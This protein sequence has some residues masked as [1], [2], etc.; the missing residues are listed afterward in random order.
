MKQAETLGETGMEKTETALSTVAEE[1]RELDLNFRDG[2]DLDVVEKGYARKLIH[3]IST[4]DGVLKNEVLKSLGDLY[5]RK[6]K[7]KKHKVEN[8]NKACALYDELLQYVRYKEER[9]VMQ[10]RIRYAEKC[11]QMVYSSKYAKDDL[12]MNVAEILH[13]VEKKA[14][15]KGNDVMILMEGYTDAFVEAI[16]DRNKRLEMESLK[17][18]GDLYLEK[19]RVGRDEA[20]FTK[21][22]GLYR[23][24]LDRCEDSDGREILKHRIK[25]AEKVKGKVKKETGHPGIEIIA[26]ET[27]VTC[28]QTVGHTT[29]ETQEDTDSTYQEQLQEGCR[30]LQTG[31]LDTAEEHFAAALK[32]V[33]AEAQHLEETEPLCK[34]SDVYLKRGMQSRDGGDF[35]K[36]AALSNAALV[37]AREGDRKGVK[38]AILEITQSFVKHVLS[39]NETAN[40]G[41]VD[42]EKHKRMLKEDRGYVEREIKKIEQQ[43]DPYSLDDDDPMLREVEKKRAEAIKALCETIVDQRRKFIAG[44]VDECMEVMGPPPCKYAMI[45]L[46]SQATGL[47]TPYSDLEFAIL[48]EK[49]TDDNVGYFRNLTHYLHLKVINLGE[50][51]LPAMAI[52]SLN[53]FSS[54][55]P[56]D[57]W[58][59]DSVTPRGFAFDG[60]MP[61][62][63]KTPLGRGET[64]GL[65]HTP[66][67]MTEVLTDDLTFHLKKGYHLASV[68]GNVCLIAGEQELVNEYSDLWT[69]LLQDTKGALHSLQAIT[70][71]SENSEMLTVP[72]ITPSLMNVK[73]EIYRFST[74]AVSCWALLYNIQPT[75]IWETIQKM[76]K[77]GIINCE[78]AHHLMV[79]VS[80]SAELRLRTYMNNRGQVENMSALSSM[81]TDTDIKETLKK[82]FYFSNSKQ[83]M[84]YY[85]TAR[86]L[87]IFTSHLA[88]NEPMENLILFDNGLEVQAQ[89]YNGLCDYKKLKT[90]RELALQEA[91]HEYGKDT[92]HP[93]IATSLD[94]LGVAWS[95]LGDDRKAIT[96]F[97][98]SLQMR[99]PI[100]GEKTAH[101]DIAELFNHL[102]TSWIN[103][104][105]YS[106]AISYYEQSLQMFRSIYGEDTEH[107]LI[108]TTL[109]NLGAA[110]GHIGDHRKAVSYSEQSLQMK[111]SMYGEDSAHPDIARTLCNLGTACS[112]IGDHRKALS[113]SEQSI[114]MSR[115]IYGENT[116]H[117][118]I[119]G[120]LSNMG[121]AFDDLGEYRKAVSYYE[122]SLLMRRTI[123]GE[124]TAHPDIAKSIKKLGGAW[125]EL[126]DHRKAVSYSEQSLKMWLS[127]YGKGTAHPDI[128]DSLNNLGVAWS[129]LGD[130]RKA[131]SY[132]EQSLLMRRTIYG[133]DTAHPVIA[134]SLHNLGHAWR[135]LG[136]HR[137]AVSYSEQS[138]KMWLSVY[139][140]GTA[141][142]DIAK[143]LDILGAACSSLGDHRKAISYH[144]QLLQMRRS[145][146]GKNTA[147]PDIAK[148]L[149][150]LGHAWGKLGDHRKAVSYHE[151]ELQM[152]RRIHGENTAH[153]DV[154]NSLNNLGVTWSDLGDYRKAISYHEQSLQMKL[155]MRR[156]IHGETTA[157][158]D[159]AYSLYNLGVAWSGLGDHR[160]AVSYSEQSLKMWLSVY[161][162]G[163]AHTDIAATLYNL[164][165]NWLK[166]GE[167]KKAISYHKQALQMYCSIHGENTAHPDIADSLDN[168]GIA[169]S[170]VGDPGKTVSYLEQALQM[171][172]EIHGEDNAHTDIA[173]SLHN[174][175]ISWNDIGDHRRAVSYHEQALQMRRGIHGEDT[176]HHEI[177]GSL[178]N[179]G[180]AWSNLGDHRKATSYFKK[181]L[182]MMRSTYGGNAPHSDIDQHLNNLGIACS[183]EL[184]DHRRAVSYFEQ[185]LQ[186]GR[187]IHGEGTPHSVTAVSPYNLGVAW[188]KLGDH[189]KAVSYHEQALQMRQSIH[190]ENTAHPD[191]VES[192]AKLCHAWRNL[193]DD[194]QAGNYFRQS[195]HM[196]F[197]LMMNKISQG[198]V[199]TPEECCVC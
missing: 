148:T 88:M 23:A 131:V 104:G 114:H 132:H 163:T 117:P 22:A 134:Q 79:L 153:L 64:C 45:G 54:D 181:S 63:C 100:Y 172:R 73:R 155:Q 76:H 36:A 96:Y 130:H 47:V 59:Y 193:G 55:D 126:G 195:V 68:L 171:R 67:G 30:A 116:A 58:F 149:S 168:L 72:T 53:D 146:Y 32:A 90:C 112:D 17:S 137:K 6:A 178:L 19:G 85:N 156:S 175:G 123:Y 15:V 13:G 157:Q 57:S 5:L 185:S 102:G 77:N 49:E 84:R 107:P 108:A 111:R 50:T 173:K 46:G 109:H 160:K 176:A 136:D 70:A 2:S 162:E 133:E 113:Y 51:I 71:L 120:S 151:Q 106:K 129:C 10:H 28:P 187:S 83:L 139:G 39:I 183:N 69:E 184:G 135:N 186:M 170:I 190:G 78:N 166:L 9:E 24:A 56:L 177:A 31:D 62:A 98:Q 27:W 40:I 74:L 91:R 101:P 20:A 119:A 138:L 194:E 127:V 192:L 41:D 169:L 3:A 122:Q 86:P 92:A 191:I 66:T 34:L 167:H 179:L 35:T 38:E 81:S 196:N 37:R 103:L 82:V 145:I 48:V 33:H 142:P 43:V 65:I 199:E 144:E 124:D 99:L 95:R 105:D 158:Q 21:A 87:Q 125:S 141:H 97:D 174:L 52:K 152:Y 121:T 154:A 7:M 44:L 189:R 118:D 180:G 4:E 147:H 75:T 94:R 93:D 140:K 182:Q 29:R 164:G 110:C 42:M 18:L 197:K 16:V 60:A 11:A 128:A 89:V 25:Y 1:L 12:E 143:T 159:I 8:F 14:K 115:S 26:D 188:G 80:I 61:H 161:S 198:T 150:K 165:T